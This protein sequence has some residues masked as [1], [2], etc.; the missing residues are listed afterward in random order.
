M[1]D[2]N[3][4]YLAHEA[5]MAR[6]E[7]IVKR[8]WILCLI[9]FLAFVGS[10]LAWIVYES[11]FETVETTTTSQEI[12]QESDT[13]NNFAVGGD[14]HVETGYPNSFDNNPDKGP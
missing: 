12:M 13:G 9:I 2:L 10:N 7:R 8:L 11:Q 14:F 3:I 4:P 5:E 1:D 6:Q